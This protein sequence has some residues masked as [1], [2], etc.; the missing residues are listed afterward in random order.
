MIKG[1]I[2]PVIGAVAGIAG[3]RK[4]SLRMIRV[5]CGLIIGGMAGV[6]L[7]RHGLEL[8]GRRSFVAGI[9][10]YRGVGAGQG[11]AIIVLPNLRDRHL[12]SAHRVA[13]LAIRSQLPAMDVGVAVLASLP[14]VGEDGLNVA[15]RASHSLMH[16]T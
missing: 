1:R 4:F 7:R 11:K 15:L 12:P 14:D 2:Q 8:A 9:A 6:A 16:A 13:L 5:C 10:I 3:R